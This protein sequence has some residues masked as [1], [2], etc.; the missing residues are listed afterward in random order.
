MSCNFELRLVAGDTGAPLYATMRDRNAPADGYDVAD[1]CD[2]F[3]WAP[4]TLDG[5][6][7]M[8]IR[9]KNTTTVLD[10]ITATIIDAAAGRC[11]FSWGDTTWS[12]AGDYEGEIEIT[13]ADTKITTVYDTIKFKVREQF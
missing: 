10:T 8:K 5:T 1:P 3:S 11:V 7:V 9:L 4:I 6:V 13:G 2:P 12:N